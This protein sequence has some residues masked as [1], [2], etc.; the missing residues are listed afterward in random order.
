MINNELNKQKGLSLVELM[1]ALTLGLVILVGVSYVFLG[2]RQSYRLQDDQA[3]MQETG[4]FVLDII[5]RSV[6][7]AGW[8]DLARNNPG[9]IA[10]LG[11][12]IAGNNLVLTLQSDALGG[13][14]DC[15]GNAALAGQVIQNSFNLD[16]VND[17]LRCDGA[18]GSPPAAIGNGTALADNIEDLQILYGNDT[19]GDQSVNQYVAAPGTATIAARV[20]VLVRSENTN[21]TSTA[22]R[23]LNCAGALG[24]AVGAGAFTAAVDG[25]L[26]HAY[27][28]TFMIRNRVS[29]LP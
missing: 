5:G 22:Q 13:E 7:Q 25:R 17:Q 10:F 15:E 6:R 2:S 27:V 18:V 9:K 23:F 21:V 19:D 11:V 16:A 26:R 8:A 1:V 14:L 3:H 24:T 28:G 12:P 20:C 4:R 29:N